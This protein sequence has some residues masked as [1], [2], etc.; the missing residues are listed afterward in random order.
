MV[1]MGEMNRV[2]VDLGD[3]TYSVVVGHGAIVETASLLPATAKR[4]A[5]V[6]QFGIPTSLVPT[7]P[8][9]QVTVHEIGVGEEHKS[10][11]TIAQLCLSLIHI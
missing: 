2:T 11:T 10:L 9:H 6:T 8:N 1:Q 5:V 7:F 3:R 4:V